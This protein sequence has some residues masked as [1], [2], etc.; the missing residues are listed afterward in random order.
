M[1]CRIVECRT[2]S[3]VSIFDPKNSPK[4]LTMAKVISLVSLQK[5]LNVTAMGIS[6]AQASGEPRS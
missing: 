3:T 5:L 6:T 4:T 1:V 2:V